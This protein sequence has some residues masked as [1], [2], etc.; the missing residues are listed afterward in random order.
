V[1]EIETLKEVNELTHALGKAYDGE[2][3]LLKCLG[4]KRLSLYKER[5]GYTHLNGN[6]TFATHMTS[7]VRSNVRF[8]LNVNKLGTLENNAKTR[9][10]LYPP[11]DLVFAIFLPK[12]LVV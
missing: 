1:V 6:V 2:A 4:S 9:T 11:L 12:I 3:C 8:S 10:N 7:F 5:L